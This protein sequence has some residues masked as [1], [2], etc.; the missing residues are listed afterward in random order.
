MKLP[1]PSV[2]FGTILMGFG[3]AVMGLWLGDLVGLLILTRTLPEWSVILMTMFGLGVGYM[4]YK[5]EGAG[6]WEAFTW[7]FK[8]GRVRDFPDQYHPPEE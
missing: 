3:V 4:T 7:W 6:I 8:R 5:G 2:V 1:Y